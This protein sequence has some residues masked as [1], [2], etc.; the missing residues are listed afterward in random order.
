MK[1]RSADIWSAVRAF[2]PFL[3]SPAVNAA[4]PSL[5]EGSAT[6]P[7]LTMKLKLTSG[8]SCCSKSNI[9]MP[10]FSF[11]FLYGGSLSPSLFALSG[12]GIKTVSR[13]ING[14]VKYLF[15]IVVPHEEQFSVF[16]DRSPQLKTESNCSASSPR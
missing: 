5:P 10:F 3:R 7:A 2:V 15:N 4:N 12:A 9:V 6:D 8:T 16:S 1:S 14:K 13:I 11:T